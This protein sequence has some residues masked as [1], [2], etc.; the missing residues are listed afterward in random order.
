VPT[1]DIRPRD[2]WTEEN[3]ATLEEI[4]AELEKHRGESIAYGTWGGAASA[5][6]RR[7]WFQPLM[8]RFGVQVRDDGSSNPN[9][10]MRLMAETG[11]FDWA[12]AL[13]TTGTYAALGELGLLEPLD[14]SV[15]DNRSFAGALKNQPYIAGGG[16]L[17]S[18]PLAYSTVTYPT[19]ESRPHSMADF[20]D[21]ENF[22]GV[23][24]LDKRAWTWM[25]YVTAAYWS[26]YPEHMKTKDGTLTPA[27]IDEAYAILDELKPHVKVWA[28][29]SADC[30]VFL[31][32]GEV[33]MC[34]TGNGRFADA[35]IA[36]EPLGMAWDAGHLM[37]TFAQS[38]PMGLKAEDPEAFELAQLVIAWLSFPEINSQYSRYIAYS[39]V[40]ADAWPLLDL[41]VFDDNRPYLPTSAENA[42]T[43]WLVDE[44]WQSG[45]TD[46][47]STRYF[48]W[49]G[50]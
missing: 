41:A 4:E 1:T 20:F 35:I 26:K 49:V 27:Q 3:P 9:T 6:E 19:E 30:P 33:D 28:A 17:A 2:Q 39:P 32:S 10:K 8:D 44:V 12:F 48:E 5:A 45:V 38:I 50:Q 7:A 21:V 46:E 43:G 36:G 31:I 25:R 15:V 34:L 40:N 47:N 29:S 24:A 23:R 11:N 42:K 18:E 37:S 16:G 22:P 14:K 13:G